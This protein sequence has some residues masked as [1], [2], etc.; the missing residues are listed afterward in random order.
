MCISIFIVPFT[1]C[2]AYGSTC[3]TSFLGKL[4]PD[5]RMIAKSL[6]T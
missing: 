1:H 4:R 5:W 2:A 3:D 6:N